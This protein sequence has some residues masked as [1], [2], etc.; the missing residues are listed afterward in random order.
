SNKQLNFLQ[1]IMTLL[2]INGRAAVVLPDNV[3]FEGGAGEVLRRKLLNDFD[4]HTMLR[5]PTGIFYAQGVKANVLFFDKKPASEEP[6]TH[7]LWVY[8][9][10]TNKHFTL[11]QNP[12]EREH[13]DDFVHAYLPGQ[14]R[15]ERVESERWKS[16]TYDE[17]VARDKVNL[18]ITWMKSD[19]LNDVDSLPAPE[20]IAQEI[21]E[22]LTS[23]LAEF[24]AVAAALGETSPQDPS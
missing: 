5:L 9:L 6:W 2:D 10:R 23:A 24:E 15:E 20:V 1:H 19:S 21:I 7:K 3:L 22:D 4:L 11:K 8:D 13:L 16:F 14:S 18:D 17:L 12:L